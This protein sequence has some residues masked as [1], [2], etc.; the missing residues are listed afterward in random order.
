M[1]LSSRSGRWSVVTSVGAAVLANAG[2]SGA[3]LPPGDRYLCYKAAVS[4][5]AFVPTTAMLE[6]QFGRVG[7]DVR[8]I[9]WICNPATQNGEPPAHA[10]FHQV[11]YQIKLPVG[12]PRLPKSDHVTTDE[13]ETRTLTVVKP[14][15]LLVP[16]AKALGSGGTGTVDTTGVDHFECYKAVLAKGSPRFVSPPEAVLADEFGGTQPYEGRRVTKLCTPG[17]KE[18]QEPAGP[19]PPG[20]PVRH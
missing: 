13:S 4:Q 19:G 15:M 2:A 5:T 14:E 16:S 20:P 17:K 7:Y 9:R 10:A 1:L 12:A 18:G 11:G 3:Q 6:D 8:R